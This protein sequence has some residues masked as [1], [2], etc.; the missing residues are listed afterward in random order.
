MLRIAVAE[1]RYSFLTLLAWLAIP[2]ISVVVRPS[3]ALRDLLLLTLG[4]LL[5]WAPVAAVLTNF[6]LLNVE[7]KEKHLRLFGMLPLSRTQLAAAR[8]LRMLATPI[9][10]LG[11]SALL[12]LVGV[13]LQG[14]TFLA[15]MGS[16]WVLPA[17]LLGC[18]ALLATQLLLFD[19][20]GMLLMQLIFAG[21]VLL[22][23]TLGTVM[24][25]RML[26][27][28]L[29]LAETPLGALLALALCFALAAANIALF[30]RRTSL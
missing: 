14:P 21:L 25:E 29:Q 3:A 27:P 7:Q 10:A 4:L 6:T 23:I 1:I 15:G 16:L 2:L 5:V 8:L 18:L 17:A 30:R 22:V 20:G 26:V 11:I 9:L 28:L 13:T 12:A 24:N 19:I